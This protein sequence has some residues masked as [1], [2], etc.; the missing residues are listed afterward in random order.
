MGRCFALASAVLTAGLLAQEAPVVFEM[1]PAATTGMTWRHDNARSP[2]RFL[3][4]THGPGV[5]ILDYD[6]DG[7]MDVFLVNSGPADFS[8]PSHL[9]R[10]A[11]YRNLGGHRFADVTAEAGIGSGA[12][13]GMGA[14]AADYDNDGRV[15]I[16]SA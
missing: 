8:S 12:G 9:R 7:L 13:F 14:A 3:P 10:H 2:E 11:L 15:D 6:G 5:A 1:V 4:E 16:S